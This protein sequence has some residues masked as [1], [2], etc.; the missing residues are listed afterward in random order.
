MWP[1]PGRPPPASPVPPRTPLPR[2]STKSEGSFNQNL[3][4]LCYLGRLFPWHHIL[5]EFTF[6]LDSEETSSFRFPCLKLLKLF[7]SGLA[8]G[9]ACC[10]LGV[11]EE[12]ILPPGGRGCLHRHLDCGSLHRDALPL[13]VSVNLE[14]IAF[15]ALSVSK[16]NQVPGAENSWCL[17]PF[18]C[19]CGGGVQ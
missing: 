14:R 10:A 1:L 3:Y 6:S 18:K 17:V 16:A 2:F 7:L 9:G 4:R 11:G 8:L 12:A 5:G 19:V 13:E 15:I